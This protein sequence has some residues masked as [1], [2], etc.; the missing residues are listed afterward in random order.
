MSM[1][2][3]FDVNGTLLDI[4]ALRRPLRKIFG[5]KLSVEEWFTKVLQYSM[6]TSLAADYL[7]FSEIATSVLEMLAAG[8]GIKLSKT[9]LENIHNRLNHLPPFPDVKNSLRRLQNANFRLATLT[10]SSPSTLAAQ[11]SNAGID[12][13]FEQTLS[14]HP[15]RRYKPSPETYH[16]AARSLGVDP[17]NMLMVAA[18][19]WDLLGASRAGCRT[20]LVRR[21]GKAIWPAARRPEYVADNLTELTDRLMGEAGFPSSPVSGAKGNWFAVAGCGAAL[22]ILGRVLAKST[23]RAS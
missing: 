21:P 23:T 8:Q 10:N 11:F 17:R 9:D 16:F 2:V 22:G 3:V 18:H 7:K 4:R 14:V 6:A 13:Y 20:A 15:I 12:R 19:P 1:V 5:C